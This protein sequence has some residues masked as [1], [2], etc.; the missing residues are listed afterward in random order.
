MF[1]TEA[2]EIIKAAAHSF[3]KE[4]V[5]LEQAFGRVV[6]EKII[7]DRDYPPFNRAAMDG[8]ALR[9]EDFEKGQRKFF[10]NET[11]F[12]GQTPSTTL[13]P[14]QCYKIMTGASTPQDA[15]LIIRREDTEEENGTVTIRIDSAKRLQNIARRGEDLRGGDVII[16]KA[17]QANAAVISLLAAIGKPSILVEKLPRIALVTTGNEVKAI[18]EAVTDVQIRNSN[19]WL[20]RSLLHKQGIHPFSVAHAP[21]EPAAMHQA[22]KNA[23]Q[24]DIVISCG[25]V[26]A[27]DADFVPDTMDALGVEKLFHKLMIRPGKPTWCGKTAD[28]KMVFALPGNPLSCMVTFTLLVQ[29]YLNACYGLP[30]PISISMTLK[31][32]RTKKT[33]LDEFFPVKIIAGT[34]TVQIVPFNGSGDIRAA[35]FADGIA[36]HARE[37]PVINP[38]DQVEVLPVLLS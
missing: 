37:K 26:S 9:F 21:D 28:G 3:G 31:D 16:D 5:P 30:S 33:D 13:S 22:F 19:A 24:A 18:E 14:G 11:I 29:P 17:I 38:G 25:G 6:C 23:L 20:L 27:G 4:M 8:Y 32:S 10:V 34:S 2:Q 12:A 36:R 1:Y 7:S 15:N 35:L